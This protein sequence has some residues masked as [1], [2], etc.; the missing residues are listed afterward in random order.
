[1]VLGAVDAHQVAV[2]EFKFEGVVPI[3]SEDRHG[4]AVLSDKVRQTEIDIGCRAGEPEVV[5]VSGFYGVIRSSGAGPVQQSVR[6]IAGRGQQLAGRGGA[7]R[8]T[9]LHSKDSGVRCFEQIPE[10]AGRRILVGQ[11]VTEVDHSQIFDRVGRCHAIVRIAVACCT[12][13]RRGEGREDSG[14]HAGAY[15]AWRDPI[16]QLDLVDNVIKIFESAK[17][18]SQPIERRQPVALAINSVETF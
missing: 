3:G 1:M 7:S 8:T 15:R 5:A 18:A 17:H 10:I 6:L 13:E 4:G 11:V 2:G 14:T 16:K 9:K 12:C